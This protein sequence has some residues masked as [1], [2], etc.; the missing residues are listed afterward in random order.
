MADLHDALHLRLRLRQRDGERQTTIGGE[1]VAVVRDGI[2]VA[3]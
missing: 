1:A 2:F 3:I